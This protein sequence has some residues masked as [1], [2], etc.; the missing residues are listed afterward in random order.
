MT[1]EF[2]GTR[3][4]A[5]WNVKFDPHASAV[6]YQAPVKRVYGIGF[7]V[8]TQC[9][10]D[11]AEC[12]RILSKS[13]GPLRVVADMAEIW[14]QQRPRVWFHDPLAVACAFDDGLC[15]FEELD[16]QV[17]LDAAALGRTEGRPST[18]IPRIP[19]QA[20][21][22]VNAERFLKHYFEIAK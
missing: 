9:S 12:R 6:V 2:F 11:A 18:A 10:I 14:F 22:T 1:G 5:E 21:K 8:T 15:G 19:M 20:A 17:R 4:D 3:L 16:V 13:T 7:D